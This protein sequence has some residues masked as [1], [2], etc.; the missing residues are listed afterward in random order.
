MALRRIGQILVDLG[1]LRESQLEALLEEQQHRPGELL[2]HIAV[3]MGWIAEEQLAQALAEQMGMKVVHLSELIIPSEVLTR[4]T[5]PMAQL[6]RI[7]P[8]SFEDNTLTLATCDPQKLSAIDE[9]RSFLGCGVRVMVCTEEELVRA[10]E[11]YYS[12]GGETVETLI[13]DMEQDAELNAAVAAMQKSSTISLDS[14][15]AMAEAPGA[16]A[17]EYGA[18]DGD[19]GPCQR[20]AL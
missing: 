10:L 12:A 7:I 13:A 3:G 11:R 18:V 19:Q 14:V 15:E 2:G 4:V 17:A 1:F 6:Y 20:L 8:V 5:E 9:L 16:Q